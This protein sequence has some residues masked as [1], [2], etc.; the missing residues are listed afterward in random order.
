MTTGK[1]IAL[2]IQTLVSKVKSLLFNM[3]FRFGASQVSLVVNN[4]FPNAGDTRDIGLIPGSE[5]SPVGERAWHPTPVFLPREFHG[6]RSLVGYSPWGRR[7]RHDQGINTF[8][9]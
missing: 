4:P 5:R 6:P 7:V 3:L 1:T 9:F 2:T 8:A